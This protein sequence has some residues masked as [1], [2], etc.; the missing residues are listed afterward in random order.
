MILKSQDIPL[1]EVSG[2]ETMH[3]WPPANISLDPLLVSALVP[4]FATGVL[5]PADPAARHVALNHVG[6]ILMRH[7]QVQR[8]VPRHVCRDNGN[9]FLERVDVVHIPGCFSRA[10]IAACNFILGIL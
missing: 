7:N 10:T 6:P 4:S 8:A 9:W 1:R 2:P 3:C 5:Q